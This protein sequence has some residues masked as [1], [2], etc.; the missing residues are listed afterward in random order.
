LLGSELRRYL[1]L[2]DA[3]GVDPDVPDRLSA[4]THAAAGLR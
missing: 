1:G 3:L 4:A 2:L